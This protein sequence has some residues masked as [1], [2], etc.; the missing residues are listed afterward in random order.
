MGVRPDT[1]DILK[2][3]N[4]VFHIGGWVLHSEKG[5]AVT[6]LKFTDVPLI[7]PQPGPTSENYRG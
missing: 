6:D 2:Y 4:L 1:Y 5:C 7:P 3:T